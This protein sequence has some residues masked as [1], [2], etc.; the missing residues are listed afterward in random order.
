M[1]LPQYIEHQYYEPRDYDMLNGFN[2]LISYYKLQHKTFP[3]IFGLYSYR[4]LAEDKRHRNNSYC[5]V[6]DENMI[7]VA[8]YSL[9]P[10]F[11]QNRFFNSSTYVL[12]PD[13]TYFSTFHNFHNHGNPKSDVWFNEIENTKAHIRNY[14]NIENFKSKKLIA[15]WRGTYCN[16]NCTSVRNRTNISLRT[17][18]P[19]RT[20]AVGCH[21]ISNGID[22]H[23]PFISKRDMCN[24]YK[25]IIS[26]P[27]MGIWTWG[28]KFALLCDSVTMFPT[29]LTAGGETW[30]SRISLGLLPNVHYLPLSDNAST[31]CTEIHNHLNFIR[32]NEERVIEMI[33]AKRDIILNRLT[34][35]EVLKDFANIMLNYSKV[36]EVYDWSK[37][38][39]NFQRH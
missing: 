14:S 39:I 9:P 19:Y 1:S 18:N 5:V 32:N 27:G 20:A 16:E 7:Q 4:D 3:N 24:H 12:I 17:W 6:R 36:Y 26:I 11:S 8:S 37:S 13:F 28:L 35:E 23:G 21:K 34:K 25:A 33:K 29:P 10:I 15:I 22:T 30:E 38:S 31:L 2:S